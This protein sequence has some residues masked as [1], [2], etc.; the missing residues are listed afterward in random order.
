MA[1]TRDAVATRARILEK[2]S[3]IFARLGYEGTS[4]GEIV[5]AAKVNK[6]MVYHYFGDKEGLYRAIFRQLWGELRDWLEVEIERRIEKSNVPLDPS[7]LVLEA[8]DIVSDFMASHQ[9]FVRLMMWE[10]LEGGAIS[11]SIWVDVR[12]PLY[13][14]IEF[15]LKEAQAQGK[16]NPKLD[17]AHLIISFLG[18][19]GFYFAYAPALADMLHKDPLASETLLERKAEVK[20]LMGALL[21]SKS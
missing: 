7:S 2:S 14:Q 15:L 4:L 12:G 17:P 10:G 16:L 8:I 9:R 20:K 6:R 21:I 11:R 19:V 1:Q 5:K 13:S 3:E 18:S